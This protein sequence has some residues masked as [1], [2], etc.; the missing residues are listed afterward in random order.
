MLNPRTLIGR[1]GSTTGFRTDADISGNLA[2][3][4]RNLQRWAPSSAETDVDLSLDDSGQPWDQFQANEKLFGLKSDYD[5][6]I[7]TTSIDRSDPLYR[8]REAAASRL[9]QEIEGTSTNNA[10]IREERGIVDDDGALDEE[11]K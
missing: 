1:E 2:L 4:E 10:H 7:Y 11:E 3:R 5:E 6:N 9:A 8:Q